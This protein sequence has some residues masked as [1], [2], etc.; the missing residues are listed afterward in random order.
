MQWKAEGQAAY[1][2]RLEQVDA[3]YAQRLRAFEVESASSRAAYDA[4]QADERA[5]ANWKHCPHCG[6]LWAGSDACPEV[7]CG[8]LEAAMG[9]ARASIGCGRTFNLARDG[10]PYVPASAPPQPDASE[11]PERPAAVTH[12][13]VSCDACG[14]NPIQGVRIRCLHCPVFNL[15]LPCLAQHGSAHDAEDEWPGREEAPH[16]F[17]VL[18]EP[19]GE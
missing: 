18:H 3:E 10:R 7:T 8:V 9:Q 15:C 5:K 12:Q 14:V 11:Q 2:Q 4:F 1:V 17:E 16:V 6:V 13:N 19:V